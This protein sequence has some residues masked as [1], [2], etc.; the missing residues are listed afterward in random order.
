MPQWR[1]QGPPGFRVPDSREVR[2][3]C[4]HSPP[5]G[6]ECGG[7]HCRVVGQ[8][9]AERDRQ[10]SLR[11]R[12]HQSRDGETIGRL[13]AQHLAEARQRRGGLVGV[14]PGLDALEFDYVRAVFGQLP[15]NALG[16]ARQRRPAVDERSRQQEQADR[17]RQAG[18]GG[19]PAAGA[20]KP[21][22][23]ADGP[24]ANRFI[25]QE[26]T[27]IVGQFARRGVAAARFLGQAFEADGFQIARRA[28]VEQ[29][30][31]R[32]L[33]FHHLPQGFL[34]RPGRKWRPPGEQVV[35]NRAERI[36]IARRAY[37]VA[38]AGHLFRRHEAGRA[39]HLAGR[40][41]FRAAIQAPR[42]TEVCDVWFVALVHE[43]V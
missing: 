18:D 37:G 38:A 31:R 21:L 42:Q 17:S 36:D 15:L 40:S 43:H 19:V 7:V 27:E 33:Q 10:V 2:G 39:E 1:R 35:K 14:E 12:K 23:C 26:A 25:A 41:E 8:R 22:T 9:F 3:K 24:G 20:G 32:G 13:R 6:A 30:R 4:S 5:I 29:A 34:L 11:Q 16:H 28:S